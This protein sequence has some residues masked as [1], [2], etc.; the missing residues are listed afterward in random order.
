[1]LRILRLFLVLWLPALLSSS[2]SAQSSQLLPSEALLNRYGLTLD[3]WGQAILDPRRDR[4]QF[5]TADEQNVYV[6]AS[7]G[8]IT[9]FS[10]ASGRRLWS[11]L[12]GAPDQVGHEASSNDDLLL[13]AIGMRMY[14]L[15]KQTGD[16]QWEVRTPNHPSSAPI[17]DDQQLFLGM[18]NGR[19]FAYDLGMVHNLHRENMLPQ[20]LDRA[21]QWMFYTPREIV[22]TPVIAG[23][24]LVFASRI[25]S[26]FGVRKDDR[27]LR[28]QFESDAPI[29]TPLGY[30]NDVVLAATEAGRMYC[31]N[32][33][34]GRT[35]WAF[36][37]GSPIQQQPRVIG[38]QVFV[39]PHLEGLAALSLVSGRELW[40]R[41]QRRVVEFLAASGNRI[42]GT[43]LGGNLL[44][45]N[46]EDGA[47]IGTVPM[48]NFTI[49]VHNDRTDRIYLATEDGIV[50][51]LRE[52]ESEFPTFHLYPERRPILPEFAP[53]E[54]DEAAATE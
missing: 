14:G 22:S 25:G 39:I 28:F 51:G 24:T 54:G 1:M 42:Y 37:S 26:V 48:R 3:W 23:Q 30:S 33:Q 43:D 52:I 47:V 6:Q 18:V 27:E 49:R 9:T 20:W 4:I 5:L 36:T 53:E 46:R 21:Q 8:I 11:M 13:V 7:S 16:L 40:P 34:N 41:N 15:N 31:L 19:V 44:V 17:A 35:R 2:A 10:G 38:R 50:I 45:L 29:R 12:L 32:V